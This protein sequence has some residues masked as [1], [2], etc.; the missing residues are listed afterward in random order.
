MPVCDD[1][2]SP[3]YDGVIRKSLVTQ[4]AIGILA[5]LLL[6]GGTTARVVGV[7]VLAFWLCV[8]IVILRR[9]R[10]PTSLD[11]GMIRWGFWPVLI[12][13][14]LRQGFA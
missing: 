11:L 6:D 1:I 10:K 4:V 7:A 5:A 3:E 2:I 13:A 12:V 8:A 9:P 14:I